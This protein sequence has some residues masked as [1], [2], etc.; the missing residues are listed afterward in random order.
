MQHP[1]AKFDSNA[2]AKD[3]AEQQLQ[4]AA[5]GER[6]GTPGARQLGE[7]LAEPGA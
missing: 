2:F 1:A 5:E 3:S 4:I 7:S 6:H